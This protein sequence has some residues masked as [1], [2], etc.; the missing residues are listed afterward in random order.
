[1]LADIPKSSRMDTPRLTIAIPT[2]NSGPYLVET[3]K[4]IRAEMGPPSRDAIEVLI[5]DNASTDGTSQLIE[6]YLEPGVVKY[7]RNDR[8]RGP[9]F[10]VGRLAE[11]AGGKYI[12]FL[13]SQER[14]LPGSLQRIL[15]VLEERQPLLVLLNF[16]IFSESAGALDSANNYRRHEDLSW[17]KPFAFFRDIRGPALAMSA[18]VVRADRYRQA[19]KK[20]L[21]AENWGLYE[22]MIDCSLALSEGEQAVFVSKPCFTL[23]RESDGWWTTGRVFT[24]FLE[25]AKV[26]N[27]KLA[28]HPLCH[29]VLFRRLSG[30]ALLR[31]IVAGKKNGLMF[32]RVVIVRSLREFRSS[33]TFW[34]LGLPMMVAPNRWFQ[35]GRHSNPDA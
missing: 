24:N 9:D 14:L 34:A 2:Y 3:L 25:L 13:G 10:S 15:E 21:V 8:N 5:V 28:G 27:V 7:V 23:F 29:F 35:G 22:R 30:R 16:E 32:D 31:S 20:E 4:S 33:P 1:M 26:V 19:M 18:T 17:T 6:T 12:W 11:I